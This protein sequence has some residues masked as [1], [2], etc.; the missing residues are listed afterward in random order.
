MNAKKPQAF[1][2]CGHRANCSV[3]KSPL[4][5][6]RFQHWCKFSR[7]WSRKCCSRSRNS[8]RV[9]ELKHHAE[10]VRHLTINR[11]ASLT[12]EELEDAELQSKAQAH[13]AAQGIRPFVGCATTAWVNAVVGAGGSVSAAQQTRVDTFIKALKAASIWTKMDRIWLNGEDHFQTDVDRQCAPWRRRGSGL[14]LIR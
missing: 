14:R 9:A 6:R 11:W 5:P 8:T 4:Q 1:S 2:R 10:R 13:H 7:V 12:R 3:M